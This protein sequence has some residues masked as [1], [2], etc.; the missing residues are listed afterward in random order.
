[1]SNSES[2]G[3]TWAKQ[4][5]L[6]NYK[7]IHEHSRAVD[8]KR[9]TLL[10]IYVPGGTFLGILS[11]CKVFSNYSQWSQIKWYIIGGWLAI[12]GIIFW[13]ITLYRRWHVE[14]GR[15]NTAIH[16]SVIVE[17]STDVYKTFREL[18]KDPQKSRPVGFS[19]YVYWKGTDFW[20]AILTLATQLFAFIMLYSITVN[21]ST[22]H[23]LTQS[24]VVLG[25]TIMALLFVGYF[26]LYWG[27]LSHR[28]RSIQKKPELALGWYL[29]K[30]EPLNRETKKR[31]RTM[32]LGGLILIAN[33]VALML[34]PK[35]AELTYW[36]IFLRYSLLFTGVV[37]IVAY[38]WLRKLQL[39]EKKR[40][41]G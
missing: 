35:I 16:R 5:L 30:A 18:A 6:E 27:Y 3:L 40:S 1:M 15:I 12:S 28:E 17:K 13:I 31:R 9:D 20:M 23:D 32:I 2:G 22:A 29:Q 38:F 24:S 26:L 14:Y 39:Q 7:Q 37:L 21:K 8:R 34:T 10:S 36:F 19:P 11:Y 25:I 33:G 4:F 41:R